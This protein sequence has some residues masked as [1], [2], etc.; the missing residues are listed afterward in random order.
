MKFPK[1]EVASDITKSLRKLMKSR[2]ESSKFSYYDD[3]GDII[4]H[5]LVEINGEIIRLHDVVKNN[6]F[7][8]IDYYAVVGVV[9]LWVRDAGHSQESATS[10]TVFEKLVAKNNSVFA[11]KFFYYFD[12]EMLVNALQHRFDVVDTTL[13]QIYDKITP[14][15]RFKN[16]Y[17]DVII[18]MG[19]DAIRVN[20][21]FNSIIINMASSCDLMTKVALELNE[22]KN[23][24]YSSYPKMRSANILYGDCVKLPDELKK[25]DT[26]FA[27]DR[28]SIIQKVETIRDEV[29]HNGSL[30]FNYSL[31]YGSKGDDGETF[32]LFPDFTQEGRF[33][34]IKGRKKFYSDGDKTLNSELPKILIEFLQIAHNTLTMLNKHFYKPAH[35]DMNDI[36]KYNKEISCMTKSYGEVLMSER[37]NNKDLEQNSDSD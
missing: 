8:D 23:V 22:M 11:N 13:S 10:K 6:V 5:L 3:R 37:S 27:N 12:C 35:E 18:G 14:S 16:N 26:Y 7:D 28:P 30:D 34:S 32:I 1:K 31:Y 33:T 25:K 19:E 4:Y 24:D 2:P 21:L 15:L 36:V 9:P 29:V 20:A 17:D